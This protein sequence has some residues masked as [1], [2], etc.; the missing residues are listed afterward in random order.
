MQYVHNSVKLRHARSYGVETTGIASSNFALYRNDL[1][2]EIN[3]SRAKKYWEKSYF[4]KS[5]GGKRIVIVFYASRLVY[6]RSFITLACFP[7]QFYNK[8]V[9]NF[10]VSQHLLQVKL[11]CTFSHTRS[12]NSELYTCRYGIVIIYEYS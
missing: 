12:A 3:R 9:P 6:F 8:V 4:Q 7:E 11:T 10:H 2:S 5:Y 1:F